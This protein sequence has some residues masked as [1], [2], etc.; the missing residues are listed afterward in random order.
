M[1][2][3]EP[4]SLDHTVQ[5]GAGEDREKANCR[6]SLGRLRD[7]GS[8]CDQPVSGKVDDM[9]ILLEPQRG[10]RSPR[11]RSKG[12]LVRQG[13]AGPRSLTKAGLNIDRVRYL[14][15][16]CLSSKGSKA[17]HTLAVCSKTREK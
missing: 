4:G 6:K 10:L 11:K 8:D 7:D 5:G 16:T 17:Q 1:R 9:L 3:E 13:G 2:V 14:A 15:Q 12:P